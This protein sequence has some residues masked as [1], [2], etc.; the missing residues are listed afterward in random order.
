MTAH[1]M[2]PHGTMTPLPDALAAVR[3]RCAPLPAE[4]TALALAADRILA[5]PVRAARDLP[6]TPISMMDGYAL[7]AQDAGGPLAI[8]LELAAGDAPPARGLGPGEAARIFTGA[9][10]PAGADCVAM[11]EHCLRD[12]AALRIDPAHPLRPGQHVRRRGEEMSAGAEV[13]PAGILLRPAELALAAAC[14]TTTLLVHRRPRLA[15]LATGDELVPAGISP[16]PGQIV[17]TNSIALAQLAREAGA[18][19]LLLG[20]AP[21]DAASIARALAAAD[22][23]LLVTTGGASVGDHDCAQAALERLGGALVFHAV[24]IRPGKPILFGT[25]ARGRLFFGLPGN[26][27]ANMLGFE[28]MVRPAVRI[29]S[30]DARPERRLV[31]AEL[32]GAPIARVPGQTYFPRGRLGAAGSRLIFTAGAQ[33]SSMQIGSFAQSNAVAQLPPGEGTV[34]P[35]DEIDVL[36]LGPL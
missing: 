34:Q 24:A 20:I 14:G 27:A 33:Q 1:G 3:T 5:A 8:V 15:L 4:E 6:A 16:Q 25:A 7:R 10:L 32:R 30:G 2:K 23:D 31:R 22:A 17:E 26:P 29:L 18:E 9:P 19:P 36:V 28:L 35:G 13:L 12:G 21:D 11:Q